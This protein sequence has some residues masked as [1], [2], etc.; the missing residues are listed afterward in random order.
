MATSR[1][2]TKS[3]I[4]KAAVGDASDA[5]PTANEFK[6]VDS[7]LDTGSSSMCNTAIRP[8]IRDVPGPR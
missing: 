6:V 7:K 1:Q 3:R 8:D 5:S 2:C 4:S